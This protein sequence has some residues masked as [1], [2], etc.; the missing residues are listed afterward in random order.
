MEIRNVQLRNFLSVGN[1][2]SGIKFDKFNYIVGAN[3]SGKTNLFRAISFVNECLNNDSTNPDPFY[4]NFDLTKDL[5]VDVS[6]ELNDNEIEIFSSLIYC[7]ILS[8]RPE[9]DSIDKEEPAYELLEK[10]LTAH[11]KTIATD[12]FKHMTIMVRR[13]EARD[14]YRGDILIKLGK[15]K[16]PLYLINHNDVTRN[17]LSR[18]GGKNLSRII[19][20]WIR[21]KNRDDVNAFLKEELKKIP[22]FSFSKEEVKDFFKKIDP[23]DEDAV[24]DL[25]SVRFNEGNLRKKNYSQQIKLMEFF[26]GTNQTRQVNALDIIA[27]IFDFSLVRTADLRSKPNSFLSFEDTVQTSSINMKNLGGETLPQI[28][29]QLRNS[30]KPHVRK[31]YNEIQNEFRNLCNG[32]EFDIGIRPKEFEIVDDTEVIQPTSDFRRRSFSV[33]IENV[34]GKKTIIK[35]ELVLQFVKENISIPVEHTAAGIFEILLLLTAIIGQEGKVI[36]LDEPAVNLHPILQRKILEKIEK[37][38]VK[39]KKNQVIIITHSPYLINPESINRVW[40]MYSTQLGSGFVNVGKTLGTLGKKDRISILKNLQYS[41]VRS[42]FFSKGVVLVEGPSDKLVI[43]RVDRHLSSK[44]MGS[45]LTENDW[46]VL[47]MNGKHSFRTYLN[48][49]KKLTIQ[50]IAVMDYDALMKCDKG[51]KID[52]E[53]VPISAIPQSLYL[54]KQLSTEQINQLKE[55]S[56]S[57]ENSWYPHSKYHVLDKLAKDN[58][59]FVFTKDLEGVLQTQISKKES[60]PLKNL[61]LILEKIANNDLPPEFEYMMEFIKN[62]MMQK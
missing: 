61:N 39:K 21:K 46:Y 29:F 59:V 52:N 6:V 17:S 32:L 38:I 36:L 24:H 55:L 1:G 51:E 35:N 48:M 30:T 42:I 47:E 45:N 56:K 4:H 12:L 41:D 57:L 10:F 53:N 27:R 49:A 16:N 26:G 13:K 28:L 50:Y 18:Q 43:E 22:E 31:K 15:T 62:E 60:K 7:S 2:Y 23:V 34:Q 44:N 8:E 37:Q 3:D 14:I 54:T 20:S 9:I 40:R 58:H 25:G 11:S 5:Q 33:N 19:I